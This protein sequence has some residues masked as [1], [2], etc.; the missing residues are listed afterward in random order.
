MDYYAK[1]YL[2]VKEISFYL[3]GKENAWNWYFYFGFHCHTQII[4]LV[5]FVGVSSSLWNLDLNLLFFKLENILWS[6]N[7]KFLYWVSPMYEAAS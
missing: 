4:K 2:A 1:D 5:V 7:L 6:L 3:E